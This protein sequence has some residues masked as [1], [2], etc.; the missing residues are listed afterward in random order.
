MYDVEVD[1]FLVAREG[2]LLALKVLA[3]RQLEP[4]S[5]LPADIAPHAEDVNVCFG[6]V[7]AFRR[8]GLRQ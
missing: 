3:R 7:L 6:N 8:V 5:I 4:P 2:R 1:Y